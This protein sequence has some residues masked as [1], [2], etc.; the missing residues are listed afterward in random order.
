MANKKVVG[1]A[2]N[3]ME[4][5][6][7]GQ[8]KANN[9]STSNKTVFQLIAFAAP[10]CATFFLVNPMW[11]L[12]PGI[13]AKYFGLD[14]VALA[15]VI[16][17]TRLFD[18]ITDPIIGFLSDWHRSRG[19]SR[20]VWVTGGGLC[21]IVAAYFLY[22]PPENVSL[23]YYLVWS[24]LFYL[25]FTILDM[26]H[27]AWAGELI[28]DYQGRV[29]S[30]SY[31]VV[32]MYL[33][34]ILFFSMPLLPLF[35]SN[36]YTPEMLRYAAIFGGILMAIGLAFNYICAPDGEHIS[37]KSKDNFI[38]VWRSIIS[39]NPLLLFLT[40]YAAVGFGY[41]MWAGLVFVY[42]DGYLDLG[43]EIAQIFLLGN[44]AG[45]LSIPLWSHAV[46]RTDKNTVWGAGMLLNALLITGC[47][48]IKP[49]MSWIFS[50]ICV[51]GT[52]VALAGM[53]LAASAI[54]ADIS[55]YG[56]LKYSRNRAATYFALLTL[57]LKIT[58]GIGGAIALGIAGSF[59]FDATTTEQTNSAIKGVQLAFIVIPVGFSLAAFVLVFFMPITRERHAV[60][61]RWI[62]R[63]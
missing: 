43:G 48:F 47:F 18:A 5:I 11:T 62:E 55:D 44:V 21:A 22:V 52:S 7:K 13:Y 32:F 54:L 16:L 37:T 36:E 40:T 23:L 24:L 20:R 57:S 46:D 15:S 61:R 14:L 6:Y 50:L 9:I 29:R 41:G 2:L 10:S 28:P 39:N 34:Q 38:T 63:N 33:G 8:G 59:G 30:Y 31:R 12:L 58:M 1:R 3:I 19:G 53:T 27:L 51:G 35:P 45:L 42:L 26:P 4:P 60:I 25:S 49:G 56:I 17:Y